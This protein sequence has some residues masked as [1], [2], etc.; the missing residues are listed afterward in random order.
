MPSAR[1]LFSA[2]AKDDNGKK[3]YRLLVRLRVATMEVPVGTASGSEEIWSYIEEE[4]VLGARS[5]GLGPNGFRV[6]VARR[7]SWQDLTRILKRMTGRDVRNDY[8]TAVPG[9]PI[10]F[11]L[12]RNQP[13][14][15]IFVYYED[16]TFSGADYPPGDNVL[17]LSCTLDEDDPTKILITAVPQI[18]STDRPVEFLN[19]GGRMMIVSKPQMF[20]LSALTFQLLVPAH[21][22]LVIGPGVAA[23][24]QAS[25]GHHFLVKEREGMEF[26]TVLVL[27]PEVVAVAQ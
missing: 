26:E 25:A 8:A 7:D 4:P 3:Q 6:G 16:R 17:S 1:E 9:D 19:E 27:I 20:P 24:R 12:K 2:S 14:Q 5:V 18:C 11:I 10:R 23:R 13:V 22:I 21:D 15:T